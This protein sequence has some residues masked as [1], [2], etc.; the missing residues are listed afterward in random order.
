MMYEIVVIGA[1]VAGLSAAIEASRMGASVLVVEKKKEIG[2][3][4]KCGGFIPKPHELPLLP[5][6][7]DVLKYP[8]EVVINTIN[9]QRIIAPSGTSKEF[10]V[11]GDVVDRRAFDQH[12]ASVAISQG[13]EIWLSSTFL[14]L[15][16][17]GVVVRRGGEREEVGADVVIGADGAYSK[18]GREAGLLK[19]YNENDI[20][21]CRLE[22]V[23]GGEI[24]EDVLEMYFSSKFS[25]GGYGWII[26]H[27]ERKANIGVGVRP[28]S[29]NVGK[30]LRMFKNKSPASKRI[31]KSQPIATG[32]GAVPVGLPPKTCS[33]NVLLAGDSASHVLSTSGSGIPLAMLS[34]KLAGRCGVEFVSEGKPLHRYDKMWRKEMMMA[35]ERTYKIRKM[36]DRLMSSDL[37]LNLMI[38]VLTPTQMK[39]IMQGKFLLLDK[40]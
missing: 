17:K 10:E 40:V 6:I 1:G 39:A 3:P 8:D 7:E 29:T 35:I 23:E 28:P 38:K 31:A 34:G 26:P 36:C 25:P 32:G 13:T 21:S 12:L 19:D 5:N 11:D 9:T 33:G 24:D 2:S 18:V 30:K 37:R 14:S 20:S 15:T 22:V 4:L 16:K 27:S